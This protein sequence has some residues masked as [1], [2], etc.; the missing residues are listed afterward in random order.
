MVKPCKRC[1]AELELEK[2]HAVY[3]VPEYTMIGIRNTTART[4][5]QKFCS[6]VC[7][8]KYFWK[9]RPRCKS[10]PE[11]NK[12]CFESMEVIRD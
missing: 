2:W 5:P 8:K 6:A 4:S 12:K 1:G 9:R 3:L 10:N 7:A 11:G